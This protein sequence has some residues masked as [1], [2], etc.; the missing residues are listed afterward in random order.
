MAERSWGFPSFETGTINCQEGMVRPDVPNRYSPQNFSLGSRTHAR[1]AE[2]WSGVTYSFPSA[3]FG[4]TV[5]ISVGPRWS[6]WMPCSSYHFSDLRY[7]YSHLGLGGHAVQ[8]LQHFRSYR[9]R[10]SYT[11]NVFNSYELFLVIAWTHALMQSTYSVPFSIAVEV[12]HSI[13]GSSNDATERYPSN[14]RVN[15]RKSFQ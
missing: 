2:W 3:N 5:M 4:L 6:I 12:S 15:V 1:L 9:V 14:Q 7:R 10:N 11:L 8:C 13:Q